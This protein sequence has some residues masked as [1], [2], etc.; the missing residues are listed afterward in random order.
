M[1]A[2]SQ[3]ESPRALTVLSSAATTAFLLGGWFS[4][5]RMDAPARCFL[6]LE[7]SNMPEKSLE[8]ITLHLPESLKRDLQDLA[9]A[10]DRSVSEYIRHE[11]VAIVYGRMALRE[12]ANGCGERRG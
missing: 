11:L 12:G 3:S 5:C 7:H 1:S 8:T 6:C 4:P 2:H 9:L 10:A